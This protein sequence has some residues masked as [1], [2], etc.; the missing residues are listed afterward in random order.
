M[1]LCLYKN[2]QIILLKFD[3]NTAAVRLQMNRP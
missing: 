3:E 1:S 2:L